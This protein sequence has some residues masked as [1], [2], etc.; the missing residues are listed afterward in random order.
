[1]NRDTPETI[2]AKPAE[3]SPPPAA[4]Q[5]N[6]F[7]PKSPRK[8]AKSNNDQALVDDE[9]EFVDSVT[10]SLSTWTNNKSSNIR[11]GDEDEDYYY[12]DDADADADADYY[13]DRKEKKTP[14]FFKRKKEEQD[15][16]VECLSPVLSIPEPAS[17]VTRYGNNEDDEYIN[18]YYDFGDDD[19]DG[20]NNNFGDDDSDDNDSGVEDYDNDY[21]YDYGDVKD[22]ASEYDYEYDIYNEDDGDNDN[23]GKFRE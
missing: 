20:A 21:K 5:Y 16:I 7:R 4:G 17:F 10:S 15:E 11:Q 8:A 12:D 3:E 13:E 23:L 19:D 1:M 9:S 18:H 14:W 2:S 22:D 6:L